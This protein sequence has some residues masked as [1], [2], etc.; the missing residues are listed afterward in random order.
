M[1]PLHT[2]LISWLSRTSFTTKTLAQPVV[3]SSC[4]P[5]KWSV[6]VSQVSSETC[7]STQPPCTGQPTCQTLL[8]TPR[9]T[10]A[11]RPPL[12]TVAVSASFVSFSLVSLPTSSCQPSSCHGCPQ[13]QSCAWQTTTTTPTA[14]SALVS[15]VLASSLSVSTGT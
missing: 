7:S 15:K 4:L 3:S 9:F 8:Y 2:P 12:L 10:T 13:S 1:V 6:T 11:Q 5:L 14:C